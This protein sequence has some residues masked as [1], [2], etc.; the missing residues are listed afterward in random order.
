MNRWKLIRFEH[1]LSQGELAAKSGVSPRTIARIEAE[2]DLDPN[3]K[4][5]HGL[6]QAYDMTVAELLAWPQDGEEAA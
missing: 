6:A 1:G 2:D 4:T 5:V 3:A